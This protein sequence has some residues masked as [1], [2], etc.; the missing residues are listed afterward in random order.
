MPRDPNRFSDSLRY[1]SGQ[2]QWSWLGDARDR[3][4]HKLLDVACQRDERN[5]VIG[6]ATFPESV[7]GILFER[8]T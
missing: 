8:I 4:E 5:R 1:S 6:F 3:F 7:S 2:I